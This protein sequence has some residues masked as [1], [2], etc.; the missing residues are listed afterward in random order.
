M[1]GINA[2][3]IGIGAC[4]ALRRDS[5]VLLIPMHGKMRIGSRRTRLTSK[6]SSPAA[7][8]FAVGIDLGT[9]N[10]VIAVSYNMDVS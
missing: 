10:S 7:K 9:T 2:L 8:G 4:A 1:A 3:H 6:A 5:N